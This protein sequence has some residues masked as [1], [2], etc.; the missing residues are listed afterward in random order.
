MQLNRANPL[1]AAATV[2]AIVITLNSV[3]A[4][5]LTWDT[6]PCA[7]LDLAYTGTDVVDKLIIGTSQMPAGADG[8]LGSA[9]PVI[10]VAQITG[11]GTLSV[12]SG[13]TSGFDAW[14][15]GGFANGTVPIDQRG[16]DDDPD[17]DGIPN[18]LEYAIAGRDPA[19]PNPSIGSVIAN[20][21][22]FTKRE[23]TIVLSYAILES[24]DL[25][26]ADAWTGVEG[27]SYVN[28]STTISYTLTPTTPQRNFI[29][30][31]VTQN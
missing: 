24:T 12:T 15:A 3:R 28:D 1:L 8:K 10:G 23:G 14:I 25:G 13:P 22:S 17:N 20:T 27:V 18:L 9:L 16:P 5:D 29:R 30:L 26:L 31:Q 6:F 11:D 7:T 21:L 19:V 4:A 2:A